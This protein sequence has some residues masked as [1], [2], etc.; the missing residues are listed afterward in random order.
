MN[1]RG[2]PALLGALLWLSLPV[3]ADTIALVQAPA[4]DAARV[5]VVGATRGTGLETVRLLIEKEIP[6]VAFARPT[7]DLGA[8]EA[9]NVDI[10]IIRQQQFRS[11]LQCRNSAIGHFRSATSLARRLRSFWLHLHFRPLS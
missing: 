1:A 6:V 11:N 9:L 5:L 10:I 8:L 7:S 3:A 2:W 4:A